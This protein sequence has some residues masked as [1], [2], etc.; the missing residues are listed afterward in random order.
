MSAREGR[1]GFQAPLP[2]AASAAS[3]PAVLHASVVCGRGNRRRMLV[4]LVV[5]A[6]ALAVIAV[7]GRLLEP[8]AMATDFAAKNL[9]PSIAHPFGTDWMGRDMLARTLA[10]LSTSIFVGL[11]AAGASSLIALALACLA[12]LGGPRAD[13]AVSWLVDLVMGVPHIVL[14]VL[15]SYAL[16]KG[17]WGVTVGVALTH[18]PS[19]TRVLRAEILQLREQPFLSVSRAL[20]V[21]RLRIAL[22]HLVPYVLPQF[23]VGLILLFPHAILHEA[24][25]TFLGFG[26][27]PDHPAVG[28]IL[29]ESMR[30]LSAGYWWLAIFPGASL[31]ATVGLFDRIGAL[32][33][34]LVDARTV[35]E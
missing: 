15:I 11:L 3:G 27:S 14:L 2:A 28:V 22:D 9:Q 30:Y 35:Q 1:N 21:S 6:V 23:L 4:G 8:V 32:A 5:A 17:F 26:L 19:L 31:V 18:W 34:R 29:S 16:G 20:G 24:S 10:G 12:V 13:A 25:I 33:R 7:A